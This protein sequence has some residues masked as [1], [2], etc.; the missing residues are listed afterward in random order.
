ML[1]IGCQNIENTPY[2]YL[3]GDK[4]TRKWFV[5]H[6]LSFV[7]DQVNQVKIVVS[8]LKR[9]TAKTFI[10]K[11]LVAKEQLLSTCE[12]VI[13]KKSE[14]NYRN[15]KLPPI[16]QCHFLSASEVA[17][18]FFVSRSTVGKWSEQQLKHR[19]LVRVGRYKNKMLYCLR[20]D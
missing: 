7:D 16:D 20:K 4:N 19:G 12:Q 1:I 11:S 14:R 10:C 8:E 3:K 18:R 5:C 6:H 17:Q 15:V 2:L 13:G 9:K